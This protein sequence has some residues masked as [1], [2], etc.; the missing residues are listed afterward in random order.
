[1]PR[2]EL[3]W[4][5]VPLDQYRSLSSEVQAQIDET[6]DLVLGKSPAPS[7]RGEDSARR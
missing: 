3:A 1:M 2:Y 4:S 6:L 5:D 7:K